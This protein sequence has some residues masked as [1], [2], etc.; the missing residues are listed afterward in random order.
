MVILIPSYEPDERLA[1]LV[2]DLAV[3]APEAHVVV[4][5]DGSS[6]AYEPFFA[7]AR[8]RGATVV[9]H[10]VNHGKGRALKT[11]LAHAQLHHPREGVVCADSD[12]QHRVGDVL[13]VSQRVRDG[14][15]VVLGARQF[16]GDVPA[17]SRLG[18]S[19][20]R[21]L[22]RL[23]TGRDLI[24]TQTGLRGYAAAELPGL[25]D[26]PGDRFEWEMT[27]LL[28]S[29][30]SGTPVS[31]VKIETVY[32]DGNTSSHFRPLVDS[33]RVYLPLLRFLASSL[34][35]FVVDLVALL[36]L[37]AAT[38]LLLPSVVLARLLSGGVNFAVNQRLVFG[39]A[40]TRPPRTAALRYG[41]LAGSLLAV[42][43]AL[44]RLLTGAG[45]GLLPA[46]VTAEVLLVVVSYLAQHWVVFPDTRQRGTAD[47]AAS[48]AHHAP[49][50][51]QTVALR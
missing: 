21:V 12:G 1:A 28:H 11:G 6:P 46:K 30:R 34:L 39:T 51:E 5:D 45:I 10:D 44:L 22:F 25:V 23:A 35:A 27:A 8:Q 16:T 41:A 37:H 42:N 18:N 20:T 29:T 32:L 7:A 40:G 14:D 50:D 24:D 49:Q 9:R 38:G 33:A 48:S 3:A 31:E 13:R 17:R 19:I 4:V 2:G 26:V 15:R 36:A 43:Y 47:D